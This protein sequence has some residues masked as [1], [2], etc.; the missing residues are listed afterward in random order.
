MK[1]SLVLLII[2]ILFLIS[3]CRKEE[4][5]LSSK[6][7]EINI[8]SKQSLK[9]VDEPMM[10]KADFALLNMT[11]DEKI[12]Q[13]LIVGFQGVEAGQDIKTMIQEYHAGGIILFDRNIKDAIQLQSLITQVKELNK[14]NKQPL[15]ISMDEE[16]GRV[17]RLPDESKK[18]PSSMQ[19]GSRNNRLISYKNGHAIACEL[20]KFGINMNFA[21]V[22]DIHSNPHNTVIGDR[23]FGNTPEIVTQHGIET[24]KGLQSMKI[25]PVIKH[26]PGHGD[27]DTDSHTDLPIVQ[28]DRERLDSFELVPFKEAVKSGADVVM[29]S[30]ILFPN[31]DNSGRPAT[32]S[33]IILTDILR[34]ELG[35]K[36][37]IITDD[38]E[39]DA[40]SKNFTL[41]ESVTGAVSAGADIIL[42]CHSLEK[43]KSAF[44]E[45]KA[46]VQNGSISIDIINESAKRIIRLK[47]KYLDGI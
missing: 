41:K 11:L 1:R 37:V 29:T 20:C 5:V 43:Q 21:P 10:E 12:G 46:A 8:V 9:E 7:E 39:M 42:I 33:K 24:M 30:H 27:T 14:P 36:G 2:V 18:F 40:I 31:L 34:T 35:F 15:F 45:L 19:I 13:M 22:L 16:G 3:S 25:I 23:S 4:P 26:F 44:N 32:M 28:H 6:I 17:S 47:Q 38:M